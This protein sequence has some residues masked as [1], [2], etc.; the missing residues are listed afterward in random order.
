MRAL[1]VDDSRAMRSILSKTVRALG[2]ETVEAANGQ[3]ALETLSANAIDLVLTDWHM[4]VMDGL[5]FLTTVRKDERYGQL[6]IVMVTSEA[7]ATCMAQALA[8][9][10]TEFIMK[11]FTSESIVMKLEMLGLLD[12]TTP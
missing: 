4:P 2:M 9:G 7:D 1:I 6:P 3:L 11:P 12:G 10:A 5:E 8:A